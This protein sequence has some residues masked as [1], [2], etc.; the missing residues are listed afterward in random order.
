MTE[1][2]PLPRDPIV[3]EVEEVCERLRLARR[4][5]ELDRHPE[6]PRAEFRAL[7]KA[8]LLGLT[9]PRRLGG[10]GLTSARAAVALFHLAYRAGTAFA[11]L[12]MQPEFC[13]VLAERGG[14]AMADRWFRPILAGRA[15]VG[16]HITEPT[17]GSDALAMALQV[18]RRGKDYVLHG[19]KSEAAFAVDAEAAIVYGRAPGT[20]GAEGVTGFLVPQELSGITRSLAPADLGERWQRRGTVVYD[21]VAVPMTYRIGEEGEGFRYL[22]RELVRDRGL[23]AAIYLGV[24]RASWDETVRDVGERVTFGRRLSE[25][26][27]VTFPL[28]DDGVQLEATWLF[29]QRA[30]ARVD[31]G[32]DGAAETAMAKVRATEV[33]L[34]TLDHGIQFHG[35]SGYSSVFP[36]EQRWRDVRSGPIAHGP[37]EVLR[38]VAASRIWSKG[39]RTA[40]A[41]AGASGPPP[42][43]ARPLRTGR[44]PPRGRRA[45]SP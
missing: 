33:A 8:R 44:R 28:V 25:R 2:W 30:L 16:N 21:H 20:L 23:L 18:T 4:Y 32:A 35:G 31:E 6:F 39:S 38:G 15:L 12:A 19:T 3:G 7:G 24:A 29:T 10:R 14:P 17:A 43:S 1:L 41:G 45:A 36:H 13:S 11:K 9:A 5:R 27:A 40:S 22:R 26:Q 37:S 42:P 34:A